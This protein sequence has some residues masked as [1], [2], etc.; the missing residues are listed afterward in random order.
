VIRV[1]ELSVKTKEELELITKEFVERIKPVFGDKLKKVVLFG[2]YARGDY[3]AEADI[4]IMVMVNEDESQLRKY[5][6]EITD[7]DVDLDLKY[8]AVLST[9]LQDEM[10]FRRYL[11]V[12]PFYRNVQKEGIVLYGQ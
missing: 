8:N 6:D 9:I 12:L 3:D 2:S 4:D 5:R 1:A 7:I 10:K 11:N